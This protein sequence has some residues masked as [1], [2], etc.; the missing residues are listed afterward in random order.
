M[1]DSSIPA[2]IAAVIKLRTALEVAHEFLEQHA[3][4]ISGLARQEAWRRELHALTYFSEKVSLD[5]KAA[6]AAPAD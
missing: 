1:I 6:L 4:K 5:L 3:D 2:T